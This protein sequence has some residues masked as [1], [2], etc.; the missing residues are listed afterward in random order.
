M[1][2]PTD[3]FHFCDTPNCNIGDIFPSLFSAITAL[4]A[5]FGV[6]QYFHGRSIE[7]SEAAKVQKNAQYL[8]AR[9]LLVELR[10]SPEVQR[11]L[12]L[13]DYSS[14]R[15]DLPDLLDVEITRSDTIIGLRTKNFVFDEKD[16]FVRSCFD[17]FL[18]QMAEIGMLIDRNK[19]EVDY[20]VPR[21]GWYCFRAR[22]QAHIEN[23]A[24][25]FGLHAAWVLIE[26]IAER[27]DL[28]N[29]EKKDT[30]IIKSNDPDSI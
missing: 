12:E 18:I 29:G 14:S 22:D 9:K 1:T 10:K 2:K 30:D 4:V 11:A 28:M 5:V 21:M 23:Y 17:E 8:E 6:W 24:R 27:F 16:T 7:R 15:F 3:F 13:I 26:K 19:L 20:F 25:A